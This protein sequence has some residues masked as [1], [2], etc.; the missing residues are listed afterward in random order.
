MEKQNLP[1]RLEPLGVLNRTEPQ[2]ANRHLRAC[3]ASEPEPVF[4]APCSPR[5]GL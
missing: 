3:V 5:D 2:A 4:H 1:D